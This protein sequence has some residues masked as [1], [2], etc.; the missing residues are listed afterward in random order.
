MMKKIITG[1]DRESH[2]W[3]AY[4]RYNKTEYAYA[5]AKTQEEAISQ[6]AD[7][8]AQR[9]ADIVDSVIAH[10]QNAQKPT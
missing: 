7:I 3:Y 6:V 5:T 1:Y 9:I 2:Q 10:T 4:F 8:L